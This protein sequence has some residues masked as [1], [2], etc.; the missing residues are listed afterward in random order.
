MGPSRGAGTAG[1]E[2]SEGIV[3]E[4][5]S[6]IGECENGGK[7]RRWEEEEEEES[8]RTILRI[9]LGDCRVRA[10]LSTR[11]NGEG[12]RERHLTDS[13]ERVQVTTQVLVRNVNETTRGDVDGGSKHSEIREEPKGRRRL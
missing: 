4:T 6:D 2:A 10:A 3:V 13:T 12:R 1:V 11:S 5:G 7:R 9:S 8:E